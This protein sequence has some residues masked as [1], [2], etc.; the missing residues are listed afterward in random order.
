MEL[1]KLEQQ[2]ILRNIWS[3]V[4]VLFVICVAGII[5]FLTYT[6]RL[7]TFKQPIQIT[8]RSQIDAASVLINRKISEIETVMRL[9]KHELELL[10]PS[11]RVISH[12][13][14]TLFKVYPELLQVRWL[15]L[16]GNEI[17]RLELTHDG[18]L[19]EVDESAL[20]NKASRYYFTA[21]ISLVPDE[22]FITQIDL[23]VE[24][25]VVQRPFYP[26]VRAVTKATQAELGTGI[27][28]INFDLRP[29]LDN[30]NTLNTATSYLLVGAGTSKWILHPN[31]D[32]EWTIDLSTPPAN[33]VLEVPHLWH[34]LSTQD[35]VPSQTMG[36][37]IITAYRIKSSH[38][39]VGGMQEI[40]L[41]AKSK[42]DLLSGLK[43]KAM[44]HA[45]VMSFVLCAFGLIVLILYVK[46]F[47][48]LKELSKALKS[49]RDSLKTA[50]AQ[51]NML[52]SELA[53]SQKLS[54][55]SIMV[56]GLAHELNTPVGAT[57]MALSNLKSLLDTLSERAKNGLTKAQFEH[58]I[59]QSEKVILLAD[60]NNQRAINLVK[61]FKRLSFER[62][63]DDNSTFNVLDTINILKQS[64]AGLF[65]Q[66][67]V[68][69]EVHIPENMNIQGDAGAFSQI[70]QILITNA[71]DHAFGAS[72]A[73]KIAIVA[74]QKNTH[75]EVRVTDNGAGIPP[76]LQSTIFD[77]FI[78]S[79]RH[80][81]H[82]GLG[83]HMA[84][85]WMYQAFKGDIKLTDSTEG[86]TQFTLV[87]PQPQ[88][89]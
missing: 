10:Q 19:V 25:G 79:K 56:A 75:V 65:K 6:D 24:N 26:T 54:S 69:L 76:S 50:L 41:L 12:A 62:A 38:H 29:L 43:F 22:I 21:G 48:R 78:T 2:G 63:K 23:N 27:L 9:F 17:V 72:T 33:I 73:N 55:L 80:K 15:D 77:P 14:K 49:E 44:K 35:S 60:S 51:Q 53:E 82:T 45:F 39:E 5:G 11:K 84:K 3:F 89:E 37:H 31:P 7:S 58:F 36:N 74:T 67:H 70:I 52:I 47:Q 85:A 42:D 81:Q 68:T 8:Q 30:L 4:W 88:N 40:Y 86:G 46:H 1:A 87:F 71:M 18:T 57:R 34:Q 28:V 61:S 59:S 20:Q 32:K 83:L 16:Q 13:F 66:P 64:M